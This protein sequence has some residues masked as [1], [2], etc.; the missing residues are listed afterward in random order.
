MTKPFESE[1]KTPAQAAP[2]LGYPESTVRKMCGSEP[3]KIRR[4]RI[5]HPGKRVRYLIHV[6]DI[7][8]HCKAQMG[9]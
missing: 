2:L 1:W 5:P 9:R 4:R 7:E 8:A 6:A 3:P